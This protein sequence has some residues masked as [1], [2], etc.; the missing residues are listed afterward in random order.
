[1]VDNVN[2]H[3]LQSL[4]AA[5]KKGKSKTNPDTE[6]PF[7]TG[8]KTFNPMKI[9]VP[10]PSKKIPEKNSLVS[11][12]YLFMA[13]KKY[14]PDLFNS[15]DVKVVKSAAAKFKLGSKGLVTMTKTKGVPSTDETYEPP[16]YYKQ[17]IRCTPVS[18]K[19]KISLCPG[20][21]TNCECERDKFMWNWVRWSKYGANLI[22]FN[23]PP[24]ITNPPRFIGVCKHQI[25]VLK[26]IKD[27]GL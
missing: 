5:K 11:F 16:H 22:A 1:M 12:F 14:Q 24:N 20:I 15:T 26:Y 13:S 18:Y 3:I 21:V 10:L 4:A 6:W 25:M 23:K 2:A 9:N 7:N 8:S 27:R 17:V 19:G